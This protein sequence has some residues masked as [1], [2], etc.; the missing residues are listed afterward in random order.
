MIPGFEVLY[1][2]ALDN[3]RIGFDS[4]RQALEQVLTRAGY[5]VNGD[6]SCSTKRAPIKVE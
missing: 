3:V 4:P 2:S 5:V 1:R 6:T